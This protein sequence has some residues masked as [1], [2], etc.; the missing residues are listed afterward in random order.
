MIKPF[1]RTGGKNYSVKY[2]LKLIPN[3][4]NTYVEL[5]SGGATLFFK[6]QK[7]KIEVINDLD[8]DIYDIFNALKYD[9]LNDKIEKL[10]QPTQTQFDNYKNNT[11]GFSKLL[12][13]KTSFAGLC[14]TYNK[15]RFSGISLK[16][17]RTIKTNFDI[18]KERLKDTIILNNDFK[19]VIEEYD[20]EDVFFYL[21]PPYTTTLNTKIY[22]YNSVT[23]QEIYN[24]L[25]SIKGKF[26]LSYN[27]TNEIRQIFKEFRIEEIT[28]RYSPTSKANI[29]IVKELIIMNY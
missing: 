4:F 1:G 19:K 13:I 14:K 22:K 11:D 3:N 27:D 15:Y 2:L 25:H 17:T 8:K 7:S 16:N 23:P 10:R 20:N 26:M 29:K 24:A 21:D 12:T 9:N 6:L 18:Y 28:T 5:F